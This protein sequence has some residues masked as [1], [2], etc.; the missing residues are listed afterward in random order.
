MFEKPQQEKGG[1]MK[2]EES[3]LKKL[4][5]AAAL[6]AGLLIGAQNAE[7]GK[8][9]MFDELDVEVENMNKKMSSNHKQTPNHEQQKSENKEDMFSDMDMLE[10]LQGKYATANKSERDTIRKEMARVLLAGGVAEQKLKEGKTLNLRS[11]DVQVMAHLIGDRIIGV[12]K[13]I[14]SGEISNVQFSIK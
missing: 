5:K 1:N 11:G 3:S 12:I 8:A 14:V 2:K 4:G 10:T 6:S 7:A 13:D 9:D